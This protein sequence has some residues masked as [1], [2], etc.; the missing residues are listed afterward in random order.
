MK[1]ATLHESSIAGYGMAYQII[2][3]RPKDLVP[4][5]FRPR[6]PERW[7]HPNSPMTM[8]HQ[9]KQ[10][11]EFPAQDAEQEVFVEAWTPDAPSFWLKN[12]QLQVKGD[13]SDVPES[14][15]KKAISK[16]HGDSDAMWVDRDNKWI[17]CGQDTVIVQYGPGTIHEQPKTPLQ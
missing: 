10:E 11:D 7:Y 5:L 17:R 4:D 16:M 15:I 6:A 8:R 13:I 12:G 2:G 9:P 1:L 3:A 14:A